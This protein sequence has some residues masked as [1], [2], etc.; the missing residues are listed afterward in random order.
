ME[1][2]AG[3]APGIFIVVIGFS[4]DGDI[5]RFL[6]KI[7][8]ISTFVGIGVFDVGIAAAG[9]EVDGIA[10]QRRYTPEQKSLI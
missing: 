8:L 1:R 7:R 2:S 6:G 4:A 3:D 5:K 9:S 10:V